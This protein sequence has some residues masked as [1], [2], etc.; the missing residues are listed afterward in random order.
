[1]KGRQA[2]P[3]HRLKACSVLASFDRTRMGLF[4]GEAAS[5]TA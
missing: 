3:L 1:M 5:T 4:V 2:V